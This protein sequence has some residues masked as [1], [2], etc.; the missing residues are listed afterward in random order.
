MLAQLAISSGFPHRLRA[1]ILAIDFAW[2]EPGLDPAR[3]PTALLGRL[4]RQREMQAE[5]RSISKMHLPNAR[6]GVD[7]TNPGLAAIRD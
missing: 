2:I 6:Y 7:L 3:L 1:K 5:A 4:C